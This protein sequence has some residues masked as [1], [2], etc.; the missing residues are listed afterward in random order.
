MNIS[1]LIINWNAGEYLLNCI[2]S[3]KKNCTFSKE[4]WIIDNN[5]ND[6]SIELI[7]KNHDDVN[8]IINEENIGFAKANNI[9]LKEIKTSYCL[10]LNPDVI[11]L[12]NCIE[13]LV[14]L[15][16]SKPKAAIVAPRL[17]YSDN[18]I[19]ESYGHF[20]S[21]ITETVHLLS[22]NKI[23]H[24]IRRIFLNKN[25]NKSICVDWVFG[26]CFLAKSE[27]LN[28]INGFD[29]SFFMYSEDLDLCHRLHNNNWEIWFHPTATVMHYSSLSADKKWNSIEKYI[30]KYNGF[31]NYLIKHHSKFA[32]KCFSVILIFDI[33]KK[34]IFN[35]HKI[36]K[37]SPHFYRQAINYHL[38][39][40]FTQK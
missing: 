33:I 14:D 22:I 37:N 24:F 26:A 8:I 1:F 10:L 15:M 17:I 23:F 9:G 21:I 30:N 4:I 6:N 28:Q 27:A 38:K 3:I 36:Y 5:S 39:K 31:Y 19:Q 12:P 18:R 20:P 2:E 11:L 7:K 35:S 16:E 13:Q 32:I 34:Y 40:L 25:F 29:E